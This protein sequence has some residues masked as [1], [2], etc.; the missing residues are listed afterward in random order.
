M[1]CPNCNKEY[2]GKF[3]PECGTKLIEKPSAGGLNI[4]LGDANAI[5]G[6]INLHDSHD[7]TNVDNSVHNITNTSNVVNNITTVERQKTASEELQEKKMQFNLLLEEI[8]ED[9]VMSEEEKLE[10]KNYQHQIGLDDATAQILIDNAR[11]RVH[12]STRQESLGAAAGP[13]KQLTMLF[14]TNQLPKIKAMIPRMAAFARNFNVDEVQHKYYVALAAMNPEELIRL[15]ESDLSDN[16][17]RSFW[18]YIA[19][20]KVGKNDKAEDILWGVLS[21]FETY[22]EENRALLQCVGDMADFGESAARDTLATVT[23]NYSPELKLFANAL[24]MRL[25]PELAVG[26][27]ASKS[28]CAFYDHQILTLESPQARAE[29]E[30]KAKAEAEAKAKMEA[31]RKAHAQ[32]EYEAAARKK[33]THTLS[34]TAI[35]DQLKGMMTARLVL[36]WGSSD[37]RQKFAHLPVVAMETEDRE[38]A[39]STYEKFVEA[40]M[41]VTVKSVNGLG[42]VIHDALGLEKV[43]A[44]NARREAE[45]KAKREAEAKAKREAEEKARREAE[46]KAKREAEEK[47]RL[48]AE[49]K[50]KRNV[51]EVSN[52]NLHFGA[53][54][55]TKEVR[56]DCNRSWE[57]STDLNSWGTATPGS[58]KLT[59]KIEANTDP[60][61]RTDYMKIECGNAELRIDIKQDAAE[62]KC[63]G[64][65]RS[66]TDNA[67]ALKR[68]VEVLK[69]NW[70]KECRSGCITEGGK[71]VL[72]K[73][74]NENNYEGL[75]YAEFREKI[76]EYE[77]DTSY[78]VYGAAI[79]DSGYYCLIYDEGLLSDH[80]WYGKVP[81]AMKSVLDD[82]VAKSQSFY[83]VSI[84]ENGDYAIITDERINSC[85]SNS[86]V[87]NALNKAET[88]YGEVLYADIT[89]L[90]VVACCKM[91]VYYE[92]IPTN[93]AERIQ[94]WVKAKRVI[95]FISFTD[96][97]TFIMSDEDNAATFCM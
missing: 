92:N 21:R 3:C 11:R 73:D 84:A 16:Y 10:L 89:N 2:E 88:L 59:I 90:G 63:S 14:M 75:S 33:V 24:Y 66:Y 45:A 1:Y 76:N 72:F 43:A 69:E 4:N 86:R 44:E 78:S 80:E 68:L 31:E 32:A 51:F 55:G 12:S 74:L 97:G 36:G 9:G 5:S 41:A 50:A 46:A 17:W 49:A 19:Y 85:S 52:S 64:T 23:G 95:K 40:G 79:T 20:R 56:V 71:G 28:N 18:A 65:T 54:G 82:C 67:K 25:E 91:G 13:V 29:R 77:K 38:Q 15:D 94:K 70:N 60:E 47:A 42:E 93:V 62:Y 57:I 6:G 87:Q 81:S 48:E 22:S 7:V 27:G 30:A 35:Q 37:S 53:E 61:E 83:S 58:G 8:F 26:L 96:S 34:I 39:I